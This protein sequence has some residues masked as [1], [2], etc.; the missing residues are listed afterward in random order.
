MHFHQQLHII[1][2]SLSHGFKLLD[3]DALRLD[4]N[5]QSA[6]VEGVA[7]ERGQPLLGMAQRVLNRVLDGQAVP[8]SVAPELVSHSAAKKLIHR[9]AERLSLDVPQRDLD[10]ADSRHLHHTAAHMEVM[11]Q[12]LPVLLDTVRV[13]ADEYLPE[14]FDHRRDRQRT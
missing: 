6:M 12:R 7:L 13:L 5:E 4:W 9:H 3:G 1:P 2:N 11:I 14:L 10:S 8:P